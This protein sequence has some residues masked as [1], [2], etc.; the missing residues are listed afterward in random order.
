MF[1]SGWTPLRPCLIAQVPTPAN[2][3]SQGKQSTIGCDPQHATPI[4]TVISVSL[5]ESAAESGKWDTED[6]TMIRHHDFK[7]HLGVAAFFAAAG[8]LG[9]ALALTAP[10]L[11]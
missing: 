5:S 4:R 11:A 2:R 9:T 10:V 8:L 3:D 1:R 6:E 7:V